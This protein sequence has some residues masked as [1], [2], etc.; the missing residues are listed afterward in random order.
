MLKRSLRVVE[1][2]DY[3]VE[4]G[5]KNSISDAAVAALTAR[6]AAEGAF[7]NVCINLPGIEDKKFKQD[8]LN[9][10]K[11]IREKVIKKSKEA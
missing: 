7:L 2:A 4:K 5:N 3:M 10:A 1:L 8:T 9:E 11:E 6:T